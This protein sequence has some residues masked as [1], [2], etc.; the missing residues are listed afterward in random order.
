[1]KNLK[2]GR[3]GKPVPAGQ[4]TRFANLR[5]RW[6]SYYYRLASVDAWA[7]A[8]RNNSRRRAKE[9]GVWNDLTIE[10]I[11]SML[12]LDMIC[13]IIGIKMDFNQGNKVSAPNSP[14]IDR[15]NPGGPY[16]KEN[17]HVI[18]NLA[19][20]GKCQMTMA[21]LAKAGE[22]AKNQLTK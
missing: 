16:T 7:N 2:R 11:K 22:W 19:N 3:P 18:S 9:K 21:Q 1:M 4:E 5:K 12:P 15:I 6:L 14:T 13:P 8:A 17:C 20:R 10:Q